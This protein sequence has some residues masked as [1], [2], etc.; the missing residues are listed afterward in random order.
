MKLGLI[1]EDKMPASYRKRKKTDEEDEAE[2]DEAI[3][4]TE[5]VAL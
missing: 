3:T 5:T 1:S 2:E 4:N